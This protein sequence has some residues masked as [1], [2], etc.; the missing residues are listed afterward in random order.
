MENIT[1]GLRLEGQDATEDTLLSLQDW[2][3]EEHIVGIQQVKPETGVAQPGKM[4]IDPITVLSVVLASKAVI[5][6]VK[7]IH[8]WIQSTRPKVTI[9]VQVSE[10]QFVEINAENVPAMN[11]LLDQVL[12]KVN[13]LKAGD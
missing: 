4:G 8:V 2:I 12:A 13:T 1:L 11:E 6:L 5:E 3:Q 10:N 7:A 9:K